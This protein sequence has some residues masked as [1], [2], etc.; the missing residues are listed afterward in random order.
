VDLRL[1]KLFDVYFFQT[2]MNGVDLNGTEID[3]IV[4]A[5]VDLSAVNGLDTVQHTGPSTI[6][7]DTIYRSEG[8]IPL[9][10][11]EKTGVRPE[12]IN[13]LEKIKVP[14]CLYTQEQLDDWI[15]NLQKRLTI[16]MDNIAFLEEQKANMGPLGVDLRTRNELKASE[17][18]REKVERELTKWQQ[19]KDIYY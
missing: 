3:T 7:I 8:N 14:K 15:S 6:G 1:A 18:E 2:E 5:D 10:F 19:L 12:F 4:F 9:V 11:L 17:K 13:Y 16:V